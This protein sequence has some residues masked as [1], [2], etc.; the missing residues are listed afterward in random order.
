MGC[1]IPQCNNDDSF[2]Q[3]QSMG[4]TGY[5]KCA[6]PLNGYVFQETGWRPWEGPPPFD[7][8]TYW[9]TNQANCLEVRNTAI[10]ACVGVVGCFA[11]QC[12]DIGTFDTT[13][14]WQSNGYTYCA[15]PINGY[16]YPAT[17]VSPVEP[18][19]LEC[20]TYWS[21]NPVP[22]PCG[23]DI[24]LVLDVSSSISQNQFVLARDFMQAFADCDVFQGLGIRI[25]VVNYTCEADTYLF[26]T[27]ACVGVS[28]TISQLMRGDGGITRTGHA[29]NHMRLTSNFRD[30]A[31]HTAVILTDGYS[32]DDQQAAATD[33]RNAGIDLYAV[34]FG[35]Y[36]NMYALEA[37]TTSGSRVFTTSQ[38]CD[39]AQKIVADQCG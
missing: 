23:I 8:N 6:N 10:A 4:S 11:P 2:K 20:D 16:I 1:Y 34:E 37:M 35:K 19:Q 7:C 33:A 26:L 24:V 25:G 3:I 13:Q 22:P 17:A 18:I 31:H 21:T 12:T 32:E 28:Y 5:W 30:E 27:P 36:V 39:A 38:A 15:N 29:I 9:I 14:E